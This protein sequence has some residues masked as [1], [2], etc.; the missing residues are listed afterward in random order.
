MRSDRA[1][2][3]AAKKESAAPEGQGSGVE[4]EGPEGDEASPDSGVSD[5]GEG[6]SEAGPA[7]QVAVEAL[8]GLRD[9]VEDLRDR[10]LRLA[11][12][13][14]NYRKRTARE[15]NDVWS[16]AQADVVASILDVIDDLE[17]VTELDPASA[18][19][20]DV[21]TGVELVQRKM[22]RQLG[23]AGLERVGEV[24]EPF[25]PN[26]HEAIGSMPASSEDLDHTVGSILQVGYRL[27]GSLIRPARVQVCMWSDE[28]GGGGA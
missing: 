13:Y 10:Y 16:R 26:Q 27:G 21:I 12:E 3:E 8:A 5:V 23:S 17:R 18:A 9:E 7:A 1:K 11:A 4:A 20:Q 25:D 28:A 14:E 22:L 2:A 15:R 19:A 6:E 24:G